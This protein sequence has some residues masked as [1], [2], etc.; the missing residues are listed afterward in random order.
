MSIKAVFFDIDGTLL[1]D[2]GRVLASTKKA[3][4][5]LQRNGILCGIATG[6]SPI[7]LPSAVKKLPWDIFVTYNGQLVTAGSEVLYEQSFSKTQVMELAQFMDQNKRQ[8]VFGSATKLAGSS[9]MMAGQ[10]R[11]LNRLAHFIPKKLSIRFLRK[12]LQRVSRNVKG[13]R[14]HSLEILKEPIYQV[15]M[16]G[17]E[18]EAAKLA[19]Q[20]ASCTFTRSNPY[21]T[22]IVPLGGSK[23]R[24]IEE[25][26]RR[27]GFSLAEVMAFGDGLNDQEMFRAVGVAVAMGNAP[28][29]V[30]ETSDFVTASNNQDGIYL[31]LSE[32]YRLIERSKLSE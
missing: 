26:G 23:K 2:K 16:F 30:Q 27:L 12:T 4:Q 28:Q 25:A 3:I 5:E 29:E 21:I 15:V 31:A 7:S 22:D 9:L 8:A 11:W 13:M 24:G 10:R 18:K 17:T 20:F 1:T 32:N 14:Y 19:T 6:R